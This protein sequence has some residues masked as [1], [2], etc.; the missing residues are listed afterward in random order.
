MTVGNGVAGLERRGDAA[1]EARRGSHAVTAPS[2]DVVHGNRSIGQVG[3]INPINSM[4][5]FEARD[6]AEEGGKV[7]LAAFVAEDDGNLNSGPS[8][9]NKYHTCP[10]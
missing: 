1:P 2:D 7:C 4:F 6:A 3:V 9:E 10:K 8:R 5:H